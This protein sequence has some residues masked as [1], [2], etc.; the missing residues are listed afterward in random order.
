MAK[1]HLEVAKKL[2]SKKYL[3]TDPEYTAF[4]NAY[5]EGIQ[6]SGAKADSLKQGSEYDRTGK[7]RPKLFAIRI[8]YKG[9]YNSR[10]VRFNPPLQLM[11]S[12]RAF[13]ERIREI[14]EAEFVTLFD[15]KTKKND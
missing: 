7:L 11:K 15:L 1:D 8:V 6:A 14:T 4:V 9:R 10:Y 2:A 13:A 3:P 5:M 12:R